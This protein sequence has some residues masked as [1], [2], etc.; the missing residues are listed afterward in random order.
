MYT[1]SGGSTFCK[2]GDFRV[3]IKYIFW[4]GKGREQGRE[5][6]MDKGTEKGKG[7]VKGKREGKF[8]ELCG[9]SDPAAT[10]GAAL[11]RPT[12]AWGWEYSSKDLKRITKQR[13]HDKGLGGAASK[14]MGCGARH[15]N[16]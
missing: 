12:A 14:C 15:P 10:Q 13:S 8:P 6:G 2:F 16:A 5:K 11:P 7:K 3:F 9:S 1:T 4:G